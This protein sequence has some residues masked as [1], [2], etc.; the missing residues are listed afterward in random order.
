MVIV[1]VLVIPTTTYTQDFCN[2][3]MIKS[4][5]RYKWKLLACVSQQGSVSKTLFDKFFKIFLLE[6][7]CIIRQSTVCILWKG[8][9]STGHSSLSL[10][11]RTGGAI[12]HSVNTR[13][14]L[15]LLQ[16]LSK[17]LWP[18]HFNFIHTYPSAQQWDNI[19]SFFAFLKSQQQTAVPFQRELRMK[20]LMD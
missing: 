8:L 12:A 13:L 20:L 16:G 3:S 19:H 7:A 1:L 15:F 4:R 2:G 14:L 11:T 18:A 9:S 5:Y 6:Y 17:S 10:I